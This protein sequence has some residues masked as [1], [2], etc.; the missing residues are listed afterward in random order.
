MADVYAWPPVG[1][2]AENWWAESPVNVSRSILTG[3]RYASAA[4]RRRRY[5]TITVG[6][7]G[8]GAA[9]MGY[10]HVLADLLQGGV[11][12]VRLTR[13]PPNGWAD[14]VGLAGNR[15]SDPVALTTGTDPSVSITLGGSPVTL[16]TGWVLRGTASVVSGQAQIALTDGP[17]LTIIARPGEMLTLYNP[18]TDTVGA[19]A[20]VQSLAVTDVS[21]AATIK[22][23]SPLTGTGR[24]EIGTGET[25]VFEVTDMPFAPQPLSGDWS[26]TWSFAEVFADEVGTFAEVNP[27]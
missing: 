2:I 21:G 24:V 25:G 1:R 27:W 15:R 18:L 23:M 4:Q 6:N 3:A 20:M 11:N 16:F 10:L 22:L 13:L 19:S 8:R 12:F 9:G 14:A 26:T 7:A 5:A 17:P